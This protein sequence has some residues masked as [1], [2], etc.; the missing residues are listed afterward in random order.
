[1]DTA[2]QTR[3][4]AAWPWISTA[5]RLGLAA[6]WLIAGAL[7]V[8]D[9]AASAR[10]VYAYDVMSYDTAKVV[11]AVQ[12]FLEIALGLLLLIGLSTRFTAV[13]SAL[14]M[15][16]FIVGIASAWIRGL[17]IDC[18]CFSTGGA[19]GAGQDT[20]YGIDIL[21]DLAFLALS[22]LLVW[23]PRTKYSLDGILLGER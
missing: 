18:G 10:A 6:V 9:L 5:A 7:K 13:I 17:R 22:G 14:L 8:G 16:V 3:M 21:R 1:M 2:R 20:G 11:G 15:V 12:P 19:L 23:R 4:A